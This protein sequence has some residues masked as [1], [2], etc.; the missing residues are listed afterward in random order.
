MHTDVADLH[1][2]K[3]CSGSS[4]TL[5]FAL[6]EA[7]DYPGY[8]AFWNNISLNKFYCLFTCN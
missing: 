7:V 4:Q 6:L 8:T 5:G 2:L 1:K 3:L